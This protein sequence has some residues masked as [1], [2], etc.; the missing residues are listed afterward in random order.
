MRTFLLSTLAIGFLTACV[1][2]VIPMPPPNPLLMELKQ[3][4]PQKGEVV[5]SGSPGAAQGGTLVH[6]FHPHSGKGQIL[7]TGQDGSF[8]SDPIRAAE[9]D[10]LEVWSARFV[11]E[12]EPSSVLC[13]V[14]RYVEGGVTECPKKVE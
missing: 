10:Q 7:E 13:I 2:P 12:S 14:V 4:D 3:V 1:T 6:I 5:L 9:G 8:A 11:A